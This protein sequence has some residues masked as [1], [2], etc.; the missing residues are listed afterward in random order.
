VDR[1][2]TPW[3]VVTGHR[4]LYSCAARNAYVADALEPLLFAHRVDVVVV[5]HI[6][7]AQRTCPVLNSTCVSSPDAHGYLAP[8]HAIVGNAGMTCSTCKGGFLPGGWGSLEHG[9]ATLTANATDL[10]LEFFADCAKPGPTDQSC[11]G[12][13]PTLL[14][15]YNIHMPFPRGY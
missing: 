9:F 10:T 15:T 1:T 11:R 13:D 2:K 8:V 6:H 3:V 5:G 14:E 12:E 4:Q 7:V